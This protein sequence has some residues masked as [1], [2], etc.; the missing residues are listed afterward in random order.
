M[1]E[2]KSHVKFIILYFRHFSSGF[3]EFLMINLDI[4][5][6]DGNF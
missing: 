2:I 1:N 3:D 6:D 5:C 4:P